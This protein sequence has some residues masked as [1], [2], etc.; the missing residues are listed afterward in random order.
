[1][2]GNQV[3][4][5]NK[6]NKPKVFYFSFLPKTAIN[7]SLLYEINYTNIEMQIK[8]LRK[9]YIPLHKKYTLILEIKLK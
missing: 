9:K 7:K 3:I 8:T 6:F 4:K 5:K 2:S 1:M